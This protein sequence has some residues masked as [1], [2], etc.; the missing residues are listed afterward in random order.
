MLVWI[1]LIVISYYSD[2]SVILCSRNT[3]G[4]NTSFESSGVSFHKACTGAEVRTLFLPFFPA[5]S[6][7]LAL[8][9]QH[10]HC[11]DLSW[12]HTS[13]VLSVCLGLWGKANLHPG[14]KSV[15]SLQA[16]FCAMLHPFI[17]PFRPKVFL[18]LPLRGTP[19]AWC[20]PVTRS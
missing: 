18:S 8:H 14:L 10:L 16:P 13:F 2:L 6:L 19:T 5:E 11:P 20:V 3:L 17:P 9:E 15:F 4:N 1:F 12:S 7:K